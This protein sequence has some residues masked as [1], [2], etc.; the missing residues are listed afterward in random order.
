V[1][2]RHKHPRWVS[3]SLSLKYVCLYRELLLTHSTSHYVAFIR[4]SLEGR[5]SPTWVLFNDEKVVEAHDV[6]EMRK[7]AYVYFFKRA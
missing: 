3:F 6:E 2:Q 1:P 5:D 4:K 7:F